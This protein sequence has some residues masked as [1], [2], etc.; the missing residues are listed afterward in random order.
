MTLRESR[1]GPFRDQL[2]GCK[3]MFLS[4]LKTDSG[5]PVTSAQVSIL[6]EIVVPLSVSGTVQELVADT[7]SVVS[8]APKNM[9]V[10]SVSWLVLIASTDPAERHT[11]EK[12]PFLEHLKQ[13]ISCAG[14]S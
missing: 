12:W 11:L 9:S 2:Q 7:F 14:H 10:S 1:H 3:V 4:C 6:K 13:V 5:I 8:R